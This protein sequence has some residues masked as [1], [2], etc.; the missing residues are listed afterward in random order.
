MILTTLLLTKVQYRSSNDDLAAAV[1]IPIEA[2]DVLGHDPKM[3]FP[4]VHYFEQV[5][6]ERED[7]CQLLDGP[8]DLNRGVSPSPMLLKL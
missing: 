2:Q 4:L 8:G 5:L 7:S 3:N 6:S 1:I